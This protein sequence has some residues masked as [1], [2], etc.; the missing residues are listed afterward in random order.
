MDYAI[1][2]NDGHLTH[3]HSTLEF[4][5]SGRKIKL[6]LKEAE[7]FEVWIKS[8]QVSMGRKIKLKKTLRKENT[9]KLK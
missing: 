5:C 9:Q 2:L 3:N 6:T 7:E 8:T 4:K 1:V